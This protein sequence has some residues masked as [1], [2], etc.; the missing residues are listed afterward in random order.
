[1]TDY[2]D[3]CKF[4]KEQLSRNQAILNRSLQSGSSSKVDIVE[5]MDKKKDLDDKLKIHRDV[6]TKS[7]EQYNATIA[8][9]RKCWEEITTLSNLRER[10]Q[11]ESDRLALLKHTFTLTVSADY[12]QSKL[13][14][15]WGRTEQPGLTYY[16]FDERIGPKNTDHTISFLDSYWKEFS[17]R[18]PWVRRFAIFLDNASSTNKNRY[19]FSWAMEMVTNKKVDHLRIGF[20]IAG[21]TKFAPDRLFS[22]TGSAY[23]SQDVFNIHDLKGVCELGAA[24][25]IVDG[26]QVYAWRELLGDKYTNLPG[27]RKLH[28]F[29]VVRTHD[30]SVVMKVRESIYSGGW[31]DSPLKLSDASL[32]GAPTS[33]YR[34]QAHGSWGL[35]YNFCGL[36]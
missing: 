7:R 22:I 17:R 6:A 8:S 35:L 16:L 24:T 19:L 10:T 18:A 36:Q 15:Y 13:V 25:F 27:V 1:M 14:P 29:L 32:P 28:D 30:G 33:T 2:C 12:Q 31:N 26:D 23:K 21:H 3:T 34:A 11:S 20:M 4:L 9:S 5:L